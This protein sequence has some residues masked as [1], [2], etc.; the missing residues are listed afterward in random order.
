MLWGDSNSPAPF[1]SAKG[2]LVSLDFP[3]QGGG[4]LAAGVWATIARFMRRAT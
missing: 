4:L 3:L 2:G 1:K